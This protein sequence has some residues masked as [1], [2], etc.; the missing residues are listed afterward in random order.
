MI[1]GIGC[2]LSEIARMTAL[3]ADDAQDAKAL[4][5]FTPQELTFC[6]GKAARMEQLSAR[7]AAKEA[8]MKALGT[9]WAK[10]IKLTEIEVVRVAEEAPQI[11]FHGRALAHFQA[12]GGERAWLSLSHDGGAALAM[13]VIESETPSGR[14]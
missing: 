7:F 9:G 11:V 2:D 12:I 4:K 13:V 5:I 14:L 1:I 3:L 8:A 6:R 10:G